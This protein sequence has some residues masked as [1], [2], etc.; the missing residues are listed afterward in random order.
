MERV[1]F[2]IEET[3]ERIPCL[4]NPESLVLRRTA[5][6]RTRRSIGG[7]LTGAFRSDDPL[8]HTGG[9]RTELLLDLL[10]DVSLVTG[11]NPVEDVRTL[12]GRLWDLAENASGED[13]YGR[14]RLAR[15][16]WGR[17]F[18]IPGVVTAVAERL[19]HFTAEGAARR[20]WL[21]MRFV[22]VAEPA[23]RGAPE[24]ASPL[25]PEGPASAEPGALPG[26]EPVRFLEVAGSAPEGGEA[27]GEPSRPDNWAALAL[28]DTGLWRWIF[29]RTPVDDP[30]GVPA[31]TVLE[32]PASPSAEETP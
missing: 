19:E 13:G 32:V 23:P 21:R 10:F 12:T 14:L 20:S 9:G 31:G 16:I 3:G 6:V 5:G 2:L 4:L 17:S 1:V 22:R 26:E 25:P 27:D 8:L 30:L 18:N 24:T 15:F 7:P 28:G 11:E 29:A